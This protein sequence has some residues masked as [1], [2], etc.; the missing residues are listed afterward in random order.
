M[1]AQDQ[2]KHKQYDMWRTNNNAHN[3]AGDDDGG[4]SCDRGIDRMDRTLLFSTIWDIQK[5]PPRG[6]K[7]ALI[8]RP[9]MKM[10]RRKMSLEVHNVQVQRAEGVS[11]DYEDCVLRLWM[12]NEEAR[13]RKM[14]Q[15]HSVRSSIN[16]SQ[17]FTEPPNNL[18][19][20]DDDEDG[21]HGEIPVE[22]LSSDLMLPGLSGEWRPQLQV[23]IGS[24]T[25]KNR[26]KSNV[27]LKLAIDGAEQRREFIFAN[28]TQA[29]EFVQAFN[30]EKIRQ[31]KR[32]DKK[33]QGSL[34][35]IQLKKDETLD[36]LI[37]IV[38]GW[39]LPVADV[40]SS[41]PMVVCS[42]NGKEVHRTK[43]IPKT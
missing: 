17:V 11:Y 2:Q 35:G 36:L 8:P 19:E 31:P 41:D 29:D 38:S 16:A 5:P 7:K 42:I 15:H 13:R 20:D 39:G 30:R 21:T 22:L 6:T 40:T 4:D 27:Y 25:V 26:S 34:G 32:L 18:E 12:P 24:L 3:D 33:V 28:P 43:Y 1:H 14:R 9:L 37:E 23:S 10:S